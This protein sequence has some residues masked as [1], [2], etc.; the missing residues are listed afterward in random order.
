[1]DLNGVILGAGAVQNQLQTEWRQ[2][3][4]FAPD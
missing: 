2:I 3:R 1:M 4:N